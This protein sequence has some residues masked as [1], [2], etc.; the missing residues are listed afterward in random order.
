MNVCRE[1]GKK[2]PDDISLVTL[3]NTDYCLCTTPRLTSV[4]MMQNQIGIC[5][6]Q[7]ML[8]QINK[9]RRY[10]QTLVLSPE[11]VVRNSVKELH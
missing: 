8:Q 7:C 6:A 4:D 3:D 5:A 1:Q 9:E 11:L 10:K 2:V